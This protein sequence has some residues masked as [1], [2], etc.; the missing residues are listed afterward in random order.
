METFSHDNQC[1][2]WDLSR[3]PPVIK[4]RNFTAWTKFFG[5]HFVK[6]APHRKKKLQMGFTYEV[7]IL[8]YAC[9]VLRGAECEFNESINFS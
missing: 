2:G 8:F 4:A 5:L 7:C 1:I 9:S 6:F 3:L